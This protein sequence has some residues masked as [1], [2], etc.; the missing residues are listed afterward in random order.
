M[1]TP[2]TTVEEFCFG[3]KALLSNF[4]GLVY[5]YIYILSQGMLSL[6]LL[7]KESSFVW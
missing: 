2:S 6:L 4:S 1:A 3:K 7:L 5:I